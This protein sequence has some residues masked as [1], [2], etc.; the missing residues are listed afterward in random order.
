MYRTSIIQARLLTV[1]WLDC[2]QT[3]ERGSVFQ[4]RTWVRLSCWVTAYQRLKR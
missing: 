3:L 1:C 2:W 4:S